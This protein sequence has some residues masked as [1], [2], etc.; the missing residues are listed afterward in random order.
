M[1][2]FEQYL[3]ASQDEGKIMECDDALAIIEMWV[4]LAE[5][6]ASTARGADHEMRV[7]AGMHTDKQTAAA[8]AKQQKVKLTLHHPTDPKLS[9][10][11]HFTKTS[12]GL[13]AAQEAIKKHKAEHP[14]AKVSLAQAH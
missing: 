12:G 3:E 6:F 1:L 8:P 5:D 4:G 7:G 10:T 2:T 13:A 14:N 9:V 11:H